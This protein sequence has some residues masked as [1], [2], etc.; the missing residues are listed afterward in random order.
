MATPQLS[1]I[2]PMF[3]VQ[4]YVRQAIQSLVTQTHQN[5]EIVIVNDGSTDGSQDIVREFATRDPRIQLIDQVNGGYGKAV[6]VG[7]KAAQGEYVGILEP[8]DFADPEMFAV[9]LAAAKKVNADIVRCDLFQYDD[10]EG[11]GKPFCKLRDN[12]HFL[13][14]RKEGWVNV[15]HYPEVFFSQPAIW[16]CIYRR[17]FLEQNRLSVIETPGASFQDL[18][19]FVEALF[20]AE[21]FYAIDRALIYYR[22][23]SPNASSA[24]GGKKAFILFSLHDY[25][26]RAIQARDAYRYERFKGLLESLLFDHHYWQYDRLDERYQDEFLNQLAAQVRAAGRIP[27]Y[28]NDFQKRDCRAL[29]RGGPKGYR[30]SRWLTDGKLRSTALKVIRALTSPVR[31]VIFSCMVLG[32]AL[33]EILK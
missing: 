22:H 27:P 33:Q 18:P 7:L 21:R 17:S 5:M 12:L 25:L 24:K 8:D 26:H 14:E 20:C 10:S 13:G 15:Y 3:N 16:T 30:I 28:L 11:P 6:N 2:V 29:V 4:P 1:I 9:L 31:L 32:R 19:F 23:V